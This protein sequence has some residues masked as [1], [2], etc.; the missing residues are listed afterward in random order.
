VNKA[1]ISNNNIYHFA[2]LTFSLLP[3]SLGHL[4]SKNKKTK[5]NQK[6]KNKNKTS[7]PVFHSVLVP[8]LDEV[9]ICKL[10]ASHASASSSFRSKA[11]VSLRQQS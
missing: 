11:N 2:A 1:I 5:N 9:F 4:I 7:F 3:P 6:N 10:P 8:P